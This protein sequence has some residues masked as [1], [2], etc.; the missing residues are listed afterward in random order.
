MKAETLKTFKV[1]VGLCLVCSLVVSSLA[2]GLKPMQEREK[3]KFRKQNI[4]QAAGVWED[5]ADALAMFDEK[6]KAVVLDIEGGVPTTDFEPD[7]KEI[8]LETMLRT[9]GMYT[10]LDTAEDIAGVRKLEAYSV[11]Y[12]LEEEA[13]LKTLVI[14]VRGRGLWSTLYG[15]IALDMTKAHEGPQALTVTGLSYYQHGETPG[16]GGEIES[17]KFKKDWVGKK[18]FGPD[19]T[20][21]AE[22]SKQIVDEEYQV[23]TLS[24]ATLTSNGVTSMLQFWLSDQGFAPYLKTLVKSPAQ[25]AAA[26][27]NSTAKAE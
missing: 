14:P 25:T 21:K 9:D 7:A 15:F 8:N 10:M 22:L 2:V 11:L 3:E 18:V 17:K 6:I 12:R 13:Q 24:G 19:W 26:A 1:A 4:L 23:D 20:V 16:L 5:G 27:D